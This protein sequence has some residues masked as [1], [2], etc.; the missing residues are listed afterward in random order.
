MSNDEW[1]VFEDDERYP[2]YRGDGDWIQ[3]EPIQIPSGIE[4]DRVL[5]SIFL[6]D[7]NVD[8]VN[9][10][11]VVVDEENVKDPKDLRAIRFATIYEALEWLFETGLIFIN[12]KVT[13]GRY[14]EIGAA[15]PC[16]TPS[17]K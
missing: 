16:D 17:C 13:R 5:A 10:D 15:V 6:A 11:E 9:G 1:L 2:L 8:F 4:L 14:G 12:G 7:K 3:E